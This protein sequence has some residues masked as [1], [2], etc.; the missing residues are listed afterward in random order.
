MLAGDSGTFGGA[1]YS[2]P[3]AAGGGAGVA[4]GKRRGGAGADRFG[5]DLH[6]RAALSEPE[7][8]GGLH[9][10]DPRTRQR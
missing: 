9:R 6:L 3:V 4:T 1:G 10:S 8:S 7:N 5:Q 2:R